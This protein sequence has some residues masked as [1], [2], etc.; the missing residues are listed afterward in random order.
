MKYIY[1]LLLLLLPLY[2]LAMPWRGY[3]VSKNDV[4]NII[5]EYNQLLAPK[6]NQI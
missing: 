5:Q 4:P 3:I 1:A 6:P 2:L